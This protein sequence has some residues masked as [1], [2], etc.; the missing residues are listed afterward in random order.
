MNKHSESYETINAQQLASDFP[1][2]KVLLL[3]RVAQALDK[4]T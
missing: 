2:I 3:Y 4:S 1:T